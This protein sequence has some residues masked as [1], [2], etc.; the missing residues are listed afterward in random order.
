[1]ITVLV[2]IVRVL[3]EQRVEFALA[4]GLAYSAMVTPRATVDIDVLVLLH[5]RP[6]TELFQGLRASLP[7]F[8]P[9]EQPMVFRRATIWRALAGEEGR[10]VVV[11]F[12]LAEGEFHSSALARKRTVEFAG[13]ALPIVT[14]EDLVLLKALADR[15]Q[16]RADIAGVLAEH[17]E[18]LDRSYL[19]HW[20]RR[21]GI[22]VGAFGQ[23]ESA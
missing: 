21:L 22:D 10:E 9:H 7:A 4:G 6:P 23:S 1:M 3:H 12:I 8:S 20:G 19:Q 5:K 14:I 2:A 11:D 16:D 15:P 13:M 17:G 18:M